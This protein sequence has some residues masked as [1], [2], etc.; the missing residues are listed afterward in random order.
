VSSL[1][2]EFPSDPQL[3][4]VARCVVEHFGSRS[5][6]SEEQC[7]SL[8]LAVDEA[9][10]NVMRHAYC[11]QTDQPVEMVC[12]REDDR[13][14]FVLTDAGCAADLERMQPQPPDELRPGGRGVHFIRQ[15]MDQ[16]EYERSGG[17]NRLRLVKYRPTVR[18]GS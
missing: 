14:E 17:Q 18:T 10:S 3:L 9:L 1:R 5:G 16:V 7:R 11:G 2:I 4:R 15:I 13:V 6:F 12:R 8:T